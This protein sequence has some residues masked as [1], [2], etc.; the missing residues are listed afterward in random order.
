M[1]SK[2][3]G[4][5]LLIA[6]TTS[7]GGMLALPVVAES[8]GVGYTF[9]LFLAVWFLM[10]VAAICILQVNLT[11]PHG[12]NMISMAKKTLGK[13][14]QLVTWGSYLLMLYCLLSAYIAGGSDLLE[15]LFSLFHAHLNHSLAVLLFVLIFGVPVFKGVGVVDMTNR[16]LMTVKCG[17]FFAVIILLMMK[18]HG[19]H[20]QLGDITQ[21]P[22]AVLVVITSFGYAVIVPSLRDYF[23]ENDHL[24]MRAIIIGSFVPLICYML[25]VVVVLGVLP[26]SSHV[27]SL[28]Q[29]VVQ[30]DAITQNKWVINCIH[31][32]TY[33]CITTS[34]LGASLAMAD[35]IADGFKIKAKT[36]IA[37]FKILALVYVPPMAMVL[38]YPAAF[39]HGLALAGVF[40]IILLMLLPGLMALKVHLRYYWRWVVWVEVIASVA[41]LAFSVTRI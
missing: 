10:T 17:S 21:L 22:S 31:L 27:G 14:G 3:F 29:L 38:F 40:C 9:L 12:T 13:S 19:N 37:R 24:M 7:G 36:T 18:V 15:N 35:F 20:L 32:F 11:L 34:F 5:I 6:G 1:Y 28:S 8:L 25:W 30:L 23:G 41:A 33:V 39:I 4:G 2:L 26:L 16:G